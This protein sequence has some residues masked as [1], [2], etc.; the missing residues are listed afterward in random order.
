[1]WTLL[2]QTHT[3]T[4]HNTDHKMLF[5]IWGIGLSKYNNQIHQY[6]KA[7]FEAKT[8]RWHQT[9]PVPNKRILCPFSTFGAEAKLVFISIHEYIYLEKQLFL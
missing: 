9:I 8:Q 2:T 7:V 6:F 5:P 3:H 1:M 4:Q